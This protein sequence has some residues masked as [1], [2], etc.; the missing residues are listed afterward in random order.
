[1]TRKHYKAIAETLANHKRSIDAIDRARAGYRRGSHAQW[2]RTVLE[3]ALL[4][5]VDNPRFDRDKFIVA[6]G[7]TPDDA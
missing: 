7:M 4:F 3:F 6:C 5:G 2:S 1:M